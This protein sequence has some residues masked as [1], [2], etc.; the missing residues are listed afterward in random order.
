MFS[1]VMQKKCVVEKHIPSQTNCYFG[2][3]NPQASKQ[4]KISKESEYG[5]R[6][7]NQNIYQVHKKK[8]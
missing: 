4:G 1:Y 6:K 7:K 2:C 3:L 5:E 8:A